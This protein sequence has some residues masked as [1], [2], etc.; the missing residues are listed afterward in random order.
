MKIF[1]SIYDFINK[2]NLFNNNESGVRRNDSCMHQLIVIT[3]NIFSAFD[4][5]PSLEVRG[6]FL[7]LSKAF[8]R[9]WHDG[10][11]CKPNCNGIDGNLLK[12]ISHFFIRNSIF[13]VRSLVAYS[14]VRNRCHPP[15]P[16]GN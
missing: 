16:R 4:A 8:N 13:L 1:D 6:L 14:R 10:L 2:S 3:H 7:D 11:L 9:V 12:L 5:N 15:P